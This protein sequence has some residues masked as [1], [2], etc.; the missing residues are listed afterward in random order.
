MTPLAAMSRTQWPGKGAVTV[1]TLG[2][3]GLGVVRREML[4][5]LEV[6]R[7]NWILGMK[8]N[9]YNEKSMGIR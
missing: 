7:S 5:A 8:E 1:Q 9:K 6:L 4:V 3:S 2:A